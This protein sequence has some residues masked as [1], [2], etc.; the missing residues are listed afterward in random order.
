M[1][2][3]VIGGDGIGPEVTE[4]AIKV[5]RAVR[6]DVDLTH[7][8]LGAE[9][10]LRTGDILSDAER[11]KLA[12]HDTILLGAVGAPGKVPPGVLERGLLLELRFQ[13][14][15]HVNLR[16]AVLHRG[17]DS[18]LKA[19]GAVDFVVVREGTEGLY[20]GNGGSLRRGT[21][22]EV[23]SEVSQ[24]TR[25]GVER[26]VRDASPAPRRGAVSSPG[27]TRRMC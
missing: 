11:E 7:F 19:P 21:G 26:V 10:Y 4:Q 23:A 5:L 8:D 17:A 18:P 25:F 3:A 15:H 9:R 1:K 13:F 24:N 20:C 6:D 2:L 16:P 27:C 22:H 14:D 12:Q